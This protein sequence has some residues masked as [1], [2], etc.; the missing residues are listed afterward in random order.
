MKARKCSHL[1]NNIPNNFITRWMVDKVNK[2]MR[3]S[4]SYARIQK[5]YRGPR[6]GFKYDSFG[7]IIPKDY[8]KNR[9]DYID[10]KRE[11]PPVY[12]RAK[13]FSLYLR[14]R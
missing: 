4:N 5:R 6:E 13:K 14:N 3:D 10:G 11:I 12:K 2:R 9:Q 1:V 8:Y 7:S